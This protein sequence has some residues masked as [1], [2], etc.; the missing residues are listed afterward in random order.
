MAKKLGKNWSIYSAKK[1][2][3]KYCDIPLLYFKQG[4]DLQSFLQKGLSN[5]DALEQ[6]ALVLEDSAKILRKVKEIIKGKKVDIYGDVHWIIIDGDDE[7]INQ[8]VGAELGILPDLENNE[9][10]S[11]ILKGN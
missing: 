7:V 11:K 2:T 3:M 8:L 4:D 1:K 10:D 9:D 6:H 5:E